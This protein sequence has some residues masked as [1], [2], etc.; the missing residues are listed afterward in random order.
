[1]RRKTVAVIGDASA[2]KGD[3]KYELAFRTGKLLVD[4]GYRVESGGLGGVMK[5]VCEGARSSESYREGD[6]IGIVPSFDCEKANE[7]VDIVIPTG[8][9]VLRNGMTGNADAVIAIGG[10]AGTLTELAY[11][12]TLYRLMIAFR[13]VPGWSSKL[14]D[15]RIDARVRYP[16]IPDDRVYGVDSPEEAVR[17]VKQLADKY[18]RVFEGLSHIDPKNGSMPNIRG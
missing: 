17:L 2:Q 6:T 11:S 5:A 16:D 7:Y 15:T 4:A 13:N 18:T 10:G 1:M 3:A 14:A 9:D 8:M 12:W